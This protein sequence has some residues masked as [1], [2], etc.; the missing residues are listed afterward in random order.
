MYLYQIQYLN[1]VYTAH[2]NLQDFKLSQ[3]LFWRIFTP[4]NTAGRDIGMYDEQY[5]L[6]LKISVF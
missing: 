4:S 6:N 5:Y 3:S 1:I 2:I